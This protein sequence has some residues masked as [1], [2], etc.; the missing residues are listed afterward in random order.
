[1]EYLGIRS[2]LDIG[3]GK[4]VSTSWFYLQGVDSYCVE[5]SQDA[6]RSNLMPKVIQTED[7]IDMEIQ[8]IVIQHDFSRGPWWPSKTI[9]AVWCVEFLEHVGRPLM[10]NYMVAM[11]RAAIIFATHSTWGGWHHTEVRLRHLLETFPLDMQTYSVMNH[12]FSPPPF[13]LTKHTLGTSG[14]LLDSQV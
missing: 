14:S 2:L 8:R 9:D 6:L 1:M 7:G 10:F 4:G 12:F 5:G 3:C 11:K 13:K